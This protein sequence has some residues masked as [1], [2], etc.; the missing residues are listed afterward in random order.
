MTGTSKKT[1]ASKTPSVIH[2]AD[3]AR[4][5]QVGP[6]SSCT[7]TT[8]RWQGSDHGGPTTDYMNWTIDADCNMTI[9]DGIL[10]Y[11]YF[12]ASSPF[13]WSQASTY[14]TK[15]VSLTISS[16]LQLT[17]GVTDIQYWFQYMTEMKSFSAP[18]LNTLGIS[19]MQG[20]FNQCHKLKNVDLSSWDTR[21]LQDVSYMFNC[22]YALVSVNL[23]SWDTSKITKTYAM[24]DD[25]SSLVSLDL[26]GWNT[27]SLTN[28]TN[29][30]DG[31]SSLTTLDLSGWTTPQLTSTHGMFS[32]AE[33]LV[34]LDISG[35][36]TS[37][38]TDMRYMFEHT[39]LKRLRLGA[40]TANLASE[41]QAE[42]FPASPAQT[43]Y[44][45]GAFETTTLPD[46]STVYALKH[47][48]SNAVP[49][50]SYSTAVT[51]PTWFG[52]AKRSIQ[53]NHDDGTVGDYPRPCLDWDGTGT[54]TIAGDT[55]LT[56]SATRRLNWIDA[57]NNA[58]IPG[59]TLTHDGTLTVT[60]QW[61]PIPVPTVDSVTWPHDLGGGSRSIRATGT[62][63]LLR[64]DDTIPVRY[65]WTDATGTEQHKDTT[66]TV[67][68]GNWTA[69]LNDAP[70]F[71]SIAAADLKGTGT[72]ITVTA[73]VKDAGGPTGLWSDGK[74]G[75]ADMVAPELSSSYANRDGAGGIA[76]SSN[77]SQAVAEPG[78]TVTISWLDNTDTPISWPDG[79]GTTTTLTV[80]A[81]PGGRFTATKP[82]AVT[83]AKKVQYVLSDG[84]N[85][86]EPVTKKITDPITAIPLTGGPAQVWS[87]LLLILLAV[88][89][90]GATTLLR[91]RRN[92][93]LRLVTT[94]GHTMPIFHNLTTNGKTTS[95]T[96]TRNHHANRHTM[97][98]HAATHQANDHRAA[99][100]RAS[101]SQASP[102]PSHVKLRH[103]AKYAAHG[104]R[105]TK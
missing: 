37:N 41:V 1:Q 2:Q 57:N 35:W 58:Y 25:A 45:D 20:I 32:G 83:G 66:A 52:N 18:S 38:V 75:Y 98:H 6:Q 30:F 61:N 82:L 78:D 105:H 64:H 94:N 39:Y 89:L 81:G 67:N 14:G 90:I 85:T 34:S 4:Q 92:H 56:G 15:V 62:A 7:P 93:A 48:R 71:A 65:T 103:A 12:Y 87:K 49:A 23:N 10:S 91:N 102:T 59:D 72:K 40:N 28:A 21:N 51:K 31:A 104:P 101:L 80:T 36:D 9:T 42:A 11:D 63:S 60:P 29:M 13:P 33:S 50:G 26:S 96:P 16:S 46:N 3:P 44:V 74:D 43:I 99:V 95:G 17:S 77:R 55:G 100:M 54:C 84:I 5:P 79:G 86:S 27:S 68:G 88:M 22:C 76:M 69:D 53:Y 97:N 8:E 73:Q 70:S 47:F 19:H 24:F